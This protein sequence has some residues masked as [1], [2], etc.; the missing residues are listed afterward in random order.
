LGVKIVLN[1]IF[2]QPTDICLSSLLRKASAPEL[3]AKS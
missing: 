1:K 3:F 2:R